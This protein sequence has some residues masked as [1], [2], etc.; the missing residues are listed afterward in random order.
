MPGDAASNVMPIQASLH[1][2]NA[3][4]FGDWRVYISS[5][6]NRDLRDA[7]NRNR[8]FFRVIVKKIKEL[9]NGHFSYDNQKRLNH[10]NMEIPIFEAKMT[11][12][13]RLV[14][15]VDVV[16]ED[17]DP[18]QAFLFS[19]I[20]G[21]SYSRTALKIYGIYTHAQLDKR[22]WSSLGSQLA[23]RGKEYLDRVNFRTRPVVTGDNVHY[24][25]SF[26]PVEN[27][28]ASDE[29][30]S[31]LP[32][33]PK[34]D[35]EEVH[36]LLVLEKYVPLTQDVIS[37]LIANLDVSF[38][39]MLSPEEQEIIKHTQSCYVLGRSGTGKT[40]TMM[41]KMFGIEISYQELFSETVSRP[42]QV[43]V[44]Q[45]RSLAVRVEES[46][47]KLTKARAT[48]G[49]SLKALHQIA[50]EQ[51]DKMQDQAGLVDLDEEEDYRSL[52]PTKFSELKDE[53]FPLF[54]T[55]DKLCKLL[56]ADARAREHSGTRNAPTGSLVTYD[57]FLGEYWPHFSQSLTKGL[58]PSL[59]FS[60]IMGVIKG[61]EEACRAQ[62][63][64][65]S[66]SAYEKLSTR[67]QATFAT[68]RGRVYEIF[69]QYMKQ[70]RLRGDYDAADRTHKLLVALNGGLLPFLRRRFD[71]L[72]VD[73][74]Q[75][76]LMIDAYLMRYLC[77][78]PAGLF[79]AGDTAQ[80]ISVG[81]S[82]RFNELKSFLYRVEEENFSE[83]IAQAGE[84]M[85]PSTF[86]LTI[87]YR[88]HAGILDCAHTVIELIVAFW[89]YSI[90]MLQ[91]GRGVVGGIKPVFF[92]GWDQTN[93]RYE[94]FLFKATSGNYIEFGAKQC[95]LVRN[96]AARDK[97]RQH[98]GDIGLIM[99]L[100]ESKGLEFDDVLL[101]D[102]F[103][104]STVDLS[105]WRVVLNLIPE[106]DRNF[107]STPRFDDTQHAGVNTELKFLYVAITRA[108]KNMWI[109]D[110]SGRGE[111]MRLLWSSRNQI[112]DCTPETG[113][114]KLAV[115]STPEEWVQTARVLFDRKQYFHA[116]KCFERAEQPRLVRIAEA[117]HL[118]VQ[119]RQMPKTTKKE[120]AAARQSAFRRVAEAFLQCAGE[121]EVNSKDRLT[122]YRVAAEA[123]DEAG[124]YRKAA[125]T[126]ILAED[127]GTAA[128]LYRQHGFFD[129]AVRVVKQ[130]RARVPEETAESIVFVAR[131]YYFKENKLQAASELFDSIEEELEFCEDY[132]LDVAKASLLEAKG[133]IAGAAQLHLDEGRISNAISLLLKDKE[134]E[135]SQSRAAECILDGFW[136]LGL[137][138]VSPRR[139]AQDPNTKKLLSLSERVNFG[140]LT[141]MQRS[142][143][144]MFKAIL[145][146][147]TSNLRDLGL[148]FYKVKR[149]NAA[150]LCLDHFFAHFPV[151]KVSSAGEIAP[152]LEAFAIYTQVL[153]DLASR[154]DACNLA[155]VQRLFNLT[156]TTQNVFLV[157]SESFLHVQIMKGRTRI[158]STSEDGVTVNNADLAACLQQSLKFRLRDQI[159]SENT[160][161][162]QAK[163]FM[164]PCI[165]YTVLG[166]CNRPDCRRLHIERKDMTVEWYNAQIRI[167]LQQFLIVNSFPT[168]Q[169]EP[170]NNLRRHWM[171]RFYETL[172]PPHYTLGT[173]ASLRSSS[174][175]EARRGMQIVKYWCQDVLNQSTVPQSERDR[176]M[177]LTLLTRAATIMLTFDDGEN[178]SY[179]YSSPG[180]K[181][182]NTFKDFVRIRKPDPCGDKPD[183]CRD[184]SQDFLCALQ[185][186]LRSSMRC[187][188]HFIWHVI[189]KKI[190]FDVSMLCDLVESTCAALIVAKAPNPFQHVT[191][192]RSWL[193]TLFPKLDPT[194]RV[195]MVTPLEMVNLIGHLLKVIHFDVTDYL[196]FE[197]TNLLKVPAMRNVF[198]ARLCRAIALLGYND[199][200]AGDHRA[201][202]LGHL[203]KLNSNEPI[204]RPHALWI[205]YAEARQWGEIARLI[206][207]PDT[208][209]PMDM[210]VTLCHH[211]VP[212]E[213]IGYRLVVC[214]NHTEIP[215]V[216]GQ[217][218]PFTSKLRAEAKEFVPAVAQKANEAVPAPVADEGSDDDMPP[219][220]DVSDSSSEEEDNGFRDTVKPGAE[221]GAGA[222]EDTAVAAEDEEVA[223][224]FQEP[225][226]E[227]ISAANLIQRTYRQFRRRRQP[228][229][230]T[231]ARVAEFFKTAQ[232]A[233]SAIPWKTTSR[234][235][236]LLY[237]GAVP[238]T[239]VCLDIIDGWGKAQKAKNK[240]KFAKAGHEDIETN[241][242]AL[243]G[244]VQFLK[245]TR[246]L[247][248]ALEPKSKLHMKRDI[249]ELKNRVRELE[250]LC[251][252]LQA[253]HPG[254]LNEVQDDL[255]IVIQSVVVGPV[256]A[257]NKPKPELN[258]EDL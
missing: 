27:Q 232:E 208:S 12:D 152:I 223:V 244:I 21:F 185:V 149:M 207:N 91:R 184:I 93:V 143:L 250:T 248:A 132:D 194:K 64:Y 242:K 88:S 186:K 85:P 159:V 74:V 224:A 45:S 7:R 157:P 131:L 170:R 205:K 171:D 106:K 161:C 251:N 54:V 189:D 66:R 229:S 247:K 160:S 31:G 154:P 61:S 118:R 92:R 137:F 59:V 217:N 6:A 216:L 140:K 255:A 191:M 134:S 72:Y 98:V 102:F 150:L 147:E 67:T 16:P 164:A 34:E 174:V 166:R 236:R 53:H 144:A 43:F 197:N 230:S 77:R 101:F 165:S 119:A 40:A 120:E 254:A 107:V 49:K 220:Q 243:T 51:N 241:G 188:Y 172:F 235:Y 190:A 227:Q 211:G 28:A 156:M 56:E 138:A 52:L 110:R 11:R 4:G 167:Y 18:K 80:T 177:Y 111:P 108:R 78:N 136:G 163:A 109:V 183:F 69:E 95:I 124:D 104:D 63:R 215:K 252:N 25:G 178:T 86:E 221:A 13:S 122:Y 210:M 2:E 115:S 42:R 155:S 225:T 130:Y 1:L 10:S 126:Y 55:F 14:Y 181:A 57:F 75:D 168:F 116:M 15:Q 100:Y 48:H 39:P 50:R 228:S 206:N 141:G 87:N 146:N 162:Q 89:P 79:W 58:D 114:P 257:Q 202:I 36:T 121:Q 96:D 213:K 82:F 113:V 249:V 26:P 142:E 237:L 128:T 195:E 62:D 253:S 203:N 219:L 47:S 24:P 148:S 5:R 81:S 19:I 139:I 22:L 125:E 29:D 70:K 105:Q 238:H 3:D 200:C 71:Y 112:E 97:L 17:G 173:I 90:D 233:S 37:C 212:K 239:L 46:Y 60:E 246:N 209:S 94:Q 20:N 145:G 73:E 76:N 135:S 214:K 258:V 204:F 169:G 182:C 240:K 133:D 38:V 179:L 68:Q 196:L 35:M 127:Y 129:Q 99:T 187:G 193:L 175:P 44:T 41:W 176:Q 231:N 192:P 226:E 65:L 199:K 32:S 218:A 117:Y 123:L 103:E 23:R 158:Q 180:I 83:E 256:K 33:L 222:E 198:V 30:E 151:I 9:S 8:E 245:T 201:K 234:R 84:I 153:G